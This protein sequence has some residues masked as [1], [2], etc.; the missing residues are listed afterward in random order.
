MVNFGLVKDACT[1]NFADGDSSVAWKNLCNKH[2]PMT[3]SNVV[4][5]KAKFNS[6]KLTNP[7]KDPD[8]WIANLEVF[9]RKLTSM[10]H[11]VS[12]MDMMIH[13]IN[14]LPKD[15]DAITDQLEIELDGK[16]G[17]TLDI[18]NIREWLRN[19]FNKI[20]RRL[21][22]KDKYDLEGEDDEREE[23]AVSASIKKDFKGC[24]SHC[25]K[26]GHRGSDC[27]DKKND[28]MNE[29]NKEN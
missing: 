28:D 4:T 6:S 17:Y 10:G 8:E 20:K 7:R 16:F 24:C 14:N 23:K 25:G 2:D 1:D 9:P 21:N 18:S 15:Y 26:W 29:V 22:V 19:K 13:I 12:D 5:L 27:R 11:G 3:T